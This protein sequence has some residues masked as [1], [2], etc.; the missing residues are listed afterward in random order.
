MVLPLVLGVGVGVVGVVQR[1][2]EL[3]VLSAPLLGFT[4]FKSAVENQV[5]GGDD[6]ADAES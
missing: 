4:G 5:A 2:I 1:S 6:D 3:I